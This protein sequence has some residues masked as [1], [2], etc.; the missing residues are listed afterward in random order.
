MVGSIWKNSGKTELARRLIRKFSSRI[1]IV[2]LKITPF[3]ENDTVTIKKDIENISDSFHIDLYFS[4]L[5]S[6]SCH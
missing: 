1:D 5:F 3:Y 6:K 4:N 2:G